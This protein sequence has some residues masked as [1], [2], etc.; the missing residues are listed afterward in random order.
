[1]CV[2]DERFA[3]KINAQWQGTAVSSPPQQNE[4]G[5][6]TAP[7]CFQLADETPALQFLE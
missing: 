5:M 1:L 7:I 4:G 2:I 3:S 6:E